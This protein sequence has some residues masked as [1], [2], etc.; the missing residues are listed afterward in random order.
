MLRRTHILL[1]SLWLIFAGLVPAHAQT[2]ARV[3]LYDLQT[4]SY[5]TFT[6]GLDVFDST[7]AFVTGLSSA[8]IVLLEDNQPRPV[9]SLE[10]TRPG[11][12]F[13]LALDPGPYFAYRDAFAVTRFDKVV[14]ALNAWATTH[15]DPL[16]DDMSLVLNGGT[17]STHMG[18]MSAFSEALNAYKPALQTIV[19][20]PSTLSQAL[21]AVAGSS[22][23][24]GMKSAVLYITSVPAA[25]D[26][27]VL[28]NLTQRAV[29]QGVR[30]FVW[31]VA[32]SDFSSTSGATALKDLAIRTGGVYIL[33]SGVE[34]LPD[35][36]TYLAPLRHSY[37]LTYSSVVLTSGSHTLAAQVDLNGETLSTS[38]LQFELNIQPPNPILLSPPEQVVRTA[39]NAAST[40]IT[41][42]LPT[43]QQIKIVVEFPDGRVRPLVRTTLYADGQKVAEN[44]AEPFDQFVWDISSYTS[45]AQHVLTVEAQDRYGLSKISLGVPVLVTIVRPQ[46]G[47]LPFLSRNSRWVALAAILIAGVGVGLTLSWRIKRKSGAS[48]DRPRDPLTQVVQS[49]RPRRARRLPWSRPPAPTEAYLVRLKDDGQPMTSPA[50]PITAIETTFGSDPLQVTHILDDPSVS[51]LHARLTEEKGVYTLS[52]EKSVAGTW[53]NYEQLTAP[54]RLKHGDII[55]IGRF[56]YRFL[57]RVPPESL[58]VRVTPTK[59]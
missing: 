3:S 41:S 16:G 33:F 9:E 47:L 53:V 39:P 10:E 51:P 28:T 31:M 56:A 7:G 46:V 2:G 19:S 17:A 18:T 6:V 35:L 8:S 42:F 32:S 20:N 4:S 25:N 29:D 57:L 22:P 54:C 26:L 24:P 55:R 44:T 36:D 49:E 37:R 52:D 1:L 21:D 45:S 40:D 59:K 5:P 15:P 14:Q 11:V 30:V 58:P 43:Q 38:A 27:P 34:T 13:A 48:S 50:I 12:K 23:Q